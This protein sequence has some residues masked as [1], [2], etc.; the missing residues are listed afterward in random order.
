MKM[1]IRNDDVG[2]SEVNDLGMFETLD[3]GGP[4]PVM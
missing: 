3:Q 1:I 4:L 2:Y